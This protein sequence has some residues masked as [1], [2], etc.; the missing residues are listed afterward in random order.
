MV[1]RRLTLSPTSCALSIFCSVVVV[2]ND[3]GDEF[4]L[5]QFIDDEEDGGEDG[6]E[7]D[8]GNDGTLD[9]GAMRE[10]SILRVLRCGNGHP[11]I[12]PMVD[13][14]PIECGEEENVGAGLEGVLGMGMPVYHRGTLSSA[15]DNAAIRSKADKVRIAH[16]LLSGV[17]YLHRNG[18]IHRDIKGDNIM[19]SEDFSVVLID[20]SLA[21]LVNAAMF[22]GSSEPQNRFGDISGATHTVSQGTPTYRAPEVIRQEPY[23]LT[24]DCWSVGVVLLELLTGHT[25]K[26]EKD[27]Q[28]L[29]LIEEVKTKLPDQPFANL[30]RG[31]LEVDPLKR[32]GARAALNSNVFN[33]FGLT[34]SANTDKIIDLGTAFDENFDPDEDNGGNA[35]LR[36]VSNGKG[37]NSGGRRGKA[38]VDSVTDRRQKHLEKICNE[39]NC[40]HPLTRHAALT[41]ATLWATELD[42]T[43]FDVDAGT[44]TLLDCAVLAVKMFET[45]L[46]NLEDL[47]ER[48]SGPFKDWVLE[49]YKD[50][51]TSLW[52]M[53]D[54]CLLPRKVG[55]WAQ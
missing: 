16:G 21:K 27:G 9:L 44:Q 31:L 17:A 49:E 19:L 15:T 28:A 39:L 54:Y 38:R 55:A 2:Y 48:E 46:P 12:V 18:I 25:L 24:S 14:K 10:I 13:V 34:V 47:E 5:K 33:K 23:G 11:N 6:D 20:F 7:S 40:S 8:C 41:Y 26:V 37:G 30:V 43:I 45:E 36:D 3:D 32:L 53:M 22:E 1:I 35:A 52:M 4:A 51:E 50:T 42:D 29:R